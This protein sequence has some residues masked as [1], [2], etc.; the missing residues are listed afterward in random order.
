M[1][2]E[3]LNRRADVA[4]YQAKNN[5]KNQVSLLLADLELPGESNIS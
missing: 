1:S 3:E 4:L 5:G 2:A